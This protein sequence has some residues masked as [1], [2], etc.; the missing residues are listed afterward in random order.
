M[1]QTADCTGEVAFFGCRQRVADG[2]D[3]L[4]KMFEG[5]AGRICK[6]VVGRRVAETIVET[7]KQGLGNKSPNLGGYSPGFAMGMTWFLCH[8]QMDA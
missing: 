4:S 6:E 1:F 3:D 8:S 5:S 2:C 7:I